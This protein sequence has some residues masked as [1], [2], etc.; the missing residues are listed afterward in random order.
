METVTVTIGR[1]VGTEPMPPGQWAMFA[2]RTRR[3]VTSF[4]S[5]LWA[6]VD[7]ASSYEGVAEEA[8]IFYGPVNPRRHAQRLLPKYLARL[9][10]AYEQECIGY[11]FG[12]AEL[13]FADPR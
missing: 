4:T 10:E 6:D 5:E 3:A 13:A 2:E 11:T 1:N 7:C 8:H 9:A 12:T